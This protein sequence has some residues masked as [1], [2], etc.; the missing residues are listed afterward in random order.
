[1]NALY[2]V[3]TERAEQDLAGDRP[4]ALADAGPKIGADLAK[5]YEWLWKLRPQDRDRPDHPW[6]GSGGQPRVSP[7]S[8]SSHCRNRGK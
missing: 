3:Y 6:M 8:H 2:V 5:G 1:M 7:R 4:V